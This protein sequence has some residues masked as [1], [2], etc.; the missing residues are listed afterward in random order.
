M[1]YLGHGHGIRKQLHQ[2]EA[3]TEEAAQ[4]HAAMIQTVRWMSHALPLSP[5]SSALNQG[6]TLVHLKGRT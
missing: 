1:S 6:L 4:S 5:S 2:L 3:A